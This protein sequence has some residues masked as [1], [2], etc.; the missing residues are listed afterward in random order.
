MNI[1][2]E[3]AEED[4]GTLVIEPDRDDDIALACSG[5]G[6]QLRIPLFNYQARELIEKVQ[7]I[8]DAPDQ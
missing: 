5:E 7:P 1:Y 3:D 2:I 4:F 8:A 6:A